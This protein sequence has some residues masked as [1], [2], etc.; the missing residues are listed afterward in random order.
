MKPYTCPK[1]GAACSKEDILI[2]GV[3]CV[4]CKY[5][6]VDLIDIRRPTYC[7]KG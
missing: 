4:N 6:G 1:C 2:E 7:L 5:E 3:L